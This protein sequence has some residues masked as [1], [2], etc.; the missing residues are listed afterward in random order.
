MWDFVQVVVVATRV[1]EIRFGNWELRQVSGTLEVC[2]PSA[3]K[4]AWLPWHVTG[5]ANAK[6]DALEALYEKRL[7]K[8]SLQIEKEDPGIQVDHVDAFPVKTLDGQLY[9]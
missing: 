5:V 9:Y 3:G 2:L 4:K 6:E 1:L 7:K 8:K